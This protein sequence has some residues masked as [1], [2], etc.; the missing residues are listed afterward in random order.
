VPGAAVVEALR[1]D[2]ASSGGRI[3]QAGTRMPAGE[4]VEVAEGGA[5][6][7]RFL[8][9]GS[10]VSLAGGT[11]LRLADDGVQ[12]RLV[13]GRLEARVRPQGG[14]RF[15]IAAP[16]ATAT[17]VGTRFVLEAGGPTTRLAVSEGVVRFAATGGDTVQVAAGASAEAG[18]AGLLGGVHGFTLVDAARGTPLRPSALGALSIASAELPAGGVNLRVECAAGVHSIRIGAKGPRGHVAGVVDVEREVPFTI[19]GDNEGR[20]RSWHPSP[21]AY[22]LT[23]QPCGDEDGKR[24]LGDAATLALTILP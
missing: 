1:A 3:L 9:D 12:A 13:R 6:V 22:L 7:L 21:G 10:E 15:A 2:R 20:F 4:M 16:Q 23:V 5:A 8:A 14:G 11:A 17:V 18:A 24:P 19:A